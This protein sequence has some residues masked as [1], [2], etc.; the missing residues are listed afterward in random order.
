M[1]FSGFMMILLD[2]MTSYCDDFTE[3]DFI[4]VYFIEIDFNEWRLQ[5]S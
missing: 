2:Q 5:C 1:L 3:I 4:E